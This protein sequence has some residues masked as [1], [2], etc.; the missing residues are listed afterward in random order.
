MVRRRLDLSEH[1][2]ASRLA[3]LAYLI[4]ARREELGLR[5]AELADLA[6]CSTRL[7]STVEHAKSTVQVDKLLDLLEVLGLELM[8]RPGN[9][10]IVVGSTSS[11]PGGAT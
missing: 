9:R 4:R 6:E 1:E 11:P 2:R 8:V 3:D 5:Q 7:V 10:G